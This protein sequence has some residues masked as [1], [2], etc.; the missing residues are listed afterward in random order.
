MKWT[1]LIIIL[2]LS[3]LITGCAQKD[4]V[5][6]NPET[7][8]LDHYAALGGGDLDKAMALVAEDAKLWMVGNC[9]TKEA[10]QSANEAEGPPVVFEPTNFRVDGNDVY[11]KMKVT[12][13]GQVVDPGTAAY[14]YVEDGLI[15]YT[16]DCELR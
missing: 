4:A 7:I 1:S 10:F 16:G 9:M 12:V 6:I 15:K 13:D 2:T 8:I 11:F 14:A 3:I 5:Q